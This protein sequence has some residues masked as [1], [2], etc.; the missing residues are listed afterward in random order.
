MVF[1]SRKEGFPARSF[2][3][4]R[5]IFP[6]ILTSGL[7][8][9]G[10]KKTILAIILLLQVASAHADSLLE[11]TFVRFQMADYGHISVRDKS[12]KEHDFFVSNYKSFDPIADKPAQY[13]G[14]RVRVH[15][16]TVLKDIPE[17]GG[18]LKID[19][20][21]SIQILK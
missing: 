16:H 8:S 15:W 5:L 10:V 19:E 1:E 18:K 9:S 2:G 3:F 17:A 12:G 14:K 7:E 13:K 6:G 11:G 21:T 4:C 20:A